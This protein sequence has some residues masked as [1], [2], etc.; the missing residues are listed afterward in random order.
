MPRTVRDI[1][2]ENRT[3]RSR[4]KARNKP[5]YRALEPGLHLGY[6]K[7]LSGPGRWLARHYVGKQSYELET[8]GTAD[9]F[10]DAD[11]VAILSYRQ[12][13]TLARKRMVD[14]AHAAAG[15]G[16]YT[17]EDALNDYLHHLESNDRSSAKGARYRAEALILPKLGPIELA[18]LSTDQL[19]EWL[20]DIANAPSRAWTRSPVAADDAEGRR[21][22]RASANRVFAILQAALNRAWREGKVSTDAA[23]RR[24]ERFERTNRPRTSFLSIEEARRL[25]NAADPDFRQIVRAALATGARY[26]EL[27]R[28]VVSDFNSDAGS[29]AISISKSGRSRHVVL[30]EEGA[31]LFRQLCAGRSGSELILRQDDGRP[32]N[33]G[34]QFYHMRITCLRAKIEP[35]MGF[36]QLRHTWASHAVMNGAPLLVVARNLGHATTRMVEE[37][38]GHLSAGYVADAI[39]K[40]APTFG[41]VEPTN[42][43]PI[44]S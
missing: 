5:Y 28:L 1:G 2:L 21:R 41:T 20:A 37:H 8:I 18:K 7:P 17:V 32:W 12:A 30:N 43:I 34:R 33:P 16:S 27:C 25:I 35:P 14:R 36:H 23:W 19:R 15:R 11:G 44:K 40:A 9:D 4:L 42:V 13:Q 39:R 29:V 3:A 38:Y 22:R 24:V 26:G 10:S 31:E 6:R